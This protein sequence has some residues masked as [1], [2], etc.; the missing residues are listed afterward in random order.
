MNAYTNGWVEWGFCPL[1]GNLKCATKTITIRVL[2]DATI[3]KPKGHHLSL[4]KTSKIV[5]I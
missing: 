5:G 1:H 2:R 3:C 4:V